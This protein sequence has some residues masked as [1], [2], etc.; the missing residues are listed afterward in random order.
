MSPTGVAVLGATAGF[1]IFLGLPVA[2][3]PKLSVTARAALNAGA[4][5]V[6]LFLL[7]DV[8]SHAAEPVEG[9]LGH[10][11]EG[12]GSWWR[13]AGLAAVLAAGLAAGLLAFVRYDGWAAARRPERRFGPG[14]MAADELRA[15]PLT[16][17]SPAR[18]LAVLIAAGIGLHNFSEGL[19]IGQS[20]ATGAT[21]LALLLV[22]GFALHN[23]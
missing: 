11:T 8:L 3:L 7:W 13:F 21:S 9:A 19:A 15:A 18:R 22:V 16:A 12:T 2:R 14:A 5:G 17:L 23:A 6:L 20:A 1:T 4:A 10:A